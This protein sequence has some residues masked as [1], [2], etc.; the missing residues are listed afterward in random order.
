MSPAARCDDNRGG[1][2]RTNDND[3]ELSG[4]NKSGHPLWIPDWRWKK[5]V[6]RQEKDRIECR[7]SKA[8]KKLLPVPLPL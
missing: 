3:V 2:A 1:G 7:N 8:K 6:D 4:D 5:E